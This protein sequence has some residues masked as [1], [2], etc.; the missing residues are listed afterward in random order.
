MKSLK[1][2]VAFIILLGSMLLAFNLFLSINQSVS[3]YKDKIS[4][5]YSIVII[6]QT[7]IVKDSISS[8]AHIDVE[9]IVTLNNQEV[10][11]KFKGKL[12]KNSLSLLK[13][14][15]PFFYKIHLSEFPT[16]SELIK[17]TAEL[18]AMK[19]IKTVESFSKNHSQIYLLLK[20]ISTV[21]SILFIIIFLFAIIM[22][23]KQ[24][25]LWFYEHAKRLSI[26][27]LHG[28]STLYAATP[29]IKT[30]IWSSIYS[31]LIVLI[32]LFFVQNNINI[33]LPQE[34]SQIIK[35]D[36]L[37][38]GNLIATFVLSFSVAILTIMGVLFQHKRQ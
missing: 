16:T 34:L 27:Q 32:I 3:N 20:L 10:L 26:M 4:Q 14:R 33:F 13:K 36:L 37:H 25:K 22:L 35:I 24:I 30:A 5:D 38:V 11:S 6:S 7:P 19:S 21:V 8:L 18:K 28:A 9:K 1:N 29:I 17:I 15:L 23:S 12:S 31:F 2:F